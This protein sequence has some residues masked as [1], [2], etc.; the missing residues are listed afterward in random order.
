MA[1]QD[2]RLSRFEADFKQQQ[3]E[4]TNKVDTVLKAIT[5]RIAGALPS[6]TIKNLKLNVNTT[7]LVLSAR[8]YLTEDPQ[9]S[10]HIHGLINA[11]T[12]HPKKQ[13]DSHD[14]EP[15]ESEE[16]EKDSP[17]NTNTNPSTSPDPSVSFIT[18]KVRKLNSFFESLG[19]AP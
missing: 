4:M 3:S 15:V 5:D 10:T 2:A 13:S 18:E 17:G 12:I 8:S 6:N 11:V 1:S 7:T 19:L 16:K 14:D 9:C